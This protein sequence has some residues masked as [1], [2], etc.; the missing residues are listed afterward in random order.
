MKPGFQQP[1]VVSFRL[2][3][4]WKSDLNI[5]EHFNILSMFLIYFF[6]STFK[7]G[8]QKSVFEHIL[9]HQQGKS[10]FLFQISF[11][12]WVSAFLLSFQNVHNT[13]NVNEKARIFVDNPWKFKSNTVL[14]LI[15]GGVLTI[16][17]NICN[18]SVGKIVN[19]VYGDYNVRDQKN[20]G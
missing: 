6:V 14:S 7:L 11:F 20:G 13:Q 3:S 10:G 4:L 12:G 18:K 15:C 8:D 2:A 19:G 16:Q 17:S 5:S 9:S 1:N